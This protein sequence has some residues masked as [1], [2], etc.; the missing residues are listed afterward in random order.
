[1]V[2]SPM[3]AYFASSTTVF[4]RFPPAPRRS[5]QF[6][7]FAAKIAVGSAEKRNFRVRLLRGCAAVQ[8]AL[9]SNFWEPPVHYSCAVGTPFQTFQRRRA[10]R[11]FTI[12]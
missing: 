2:S 6:S 7:F 12:L 4:V 5:R 11:L 1:M 3:P 10:W 8:P 9:R